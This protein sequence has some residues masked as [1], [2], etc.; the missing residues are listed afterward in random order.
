MDTL[1]NSV[2]ATYTDRFPGLPFKYQF[3]FASRLFLWQQLPQAKA[4]LDQ[5]RPE[6]TANDNPLASLTKLDQALASQTPLAIYERLLFRALFLDTVYGLDS[7][8]ALDQLVPASKLAQLNDELLANPEEMLEL[9]STSVNFV[10]LYQRF[11]LASDQLLALAPQDTAGNLKRYCYY[12][13]HAVLGESLFYYRPVANSKRVAFCQAFAQLEPELIHHQAE[14]SLDC[15]FE[16]L[17]CCKL[18]NYQPRLAPATPP[19]ADGFI[20]EPLRSG[21]QTLAISEH[22]N[23]LFLLTQADFSPLG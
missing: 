13:T 21:R 8:S 22:R 9:S 7:R 12:L 23:A 16:F 6:F 1:Y 14:L 11:L 20:I 10:Y 18:I 5:L 2:L 4:W 15:Q 3:H 17:V 19:L